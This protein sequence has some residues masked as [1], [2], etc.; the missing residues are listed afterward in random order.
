MISDIHIGDEKFEK[1]LSGFEEFL[2]YLERN[3]DEIVLLGDIIETYWC[4]F[5]WQTAKIYKRNLEK[6]NRITKRFSENPYI[7]LS[8]NHD[9]IA[10]RKWKIPYRY[11]KEIDGMKILFTHG[12]ELDT[13]Y[14]NYFTVKF[15]EL[16]MWAGY[17]LKKMGFPFL[18]DYGYK[19]DHK[20]N[21]ENGGIQYT[22]AAKKYIVEEKFNL[23]VMGHTHVEKIVSF[24]NGKYINSGDCLTRKMFVAIDTNTK[25]TTLNYFL[26]GKVI[27]KIS[28]PLEKY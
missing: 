12:H 16:F 18:Y 17:R 5:P 6:Y 4:V 26:G 11:S 20:N 9:N 27:K 3:F 2:D 22:L 7:F 13:V 21:V 1:N 24:G 23:V 19:V 28:K 14:R 15:V 8:G 10:Y 25:K